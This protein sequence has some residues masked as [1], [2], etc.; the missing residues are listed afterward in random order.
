MDGNAEAYDGPILSDSPAPS[1]L[2]QSILPGWNFGGTQFGLFNIDLGQSADP[3][4]EREV[5][6]RVG[7]Y[8]RQLGRLGEALAVLIEHRDGEP[9]SDKDRAVLKIALGQIEQIKAMK[10]SRGTS[11]DW[12][13]SNCAARS[14]RSRPGA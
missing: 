9:L 7:S 6:D 12:T 1:R 3:A 14:V 13:R 10:P 8:G 4:F 11:A 5:L 2:T